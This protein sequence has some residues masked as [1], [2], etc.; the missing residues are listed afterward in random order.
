VNIE[1]KKRKIKHK[2]VIQ[3]TKRKSKE[4]VTKELERAPPL[5]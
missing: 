5:S 1:R 4:K 3:K 2:E